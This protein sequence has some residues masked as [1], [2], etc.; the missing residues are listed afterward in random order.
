MLTTGR[1]RTTQIGS[2]EGPRREEGGG[3][4]ND[5]CGKPPPTCCLVFEGRSANGPIIGLKDPWGP[6]KQGRPDRGGDL[7]KTRGGATLEGRR[8]I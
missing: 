5:L 8:P 7:S 6:H 1:A 2:K 4:H 3:R